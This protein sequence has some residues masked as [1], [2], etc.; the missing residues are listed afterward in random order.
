MLQR[1][2]QTAVLKVMT[3]PLAG[4]S[5]LSHIR[6][7]GLR[8]WEGPS[9]LIVAFD[10]QQVFHMILLLGQCDL[11]C[12]FCVTRLH[13][14]SW[15]EGS[16][17]DVY[18]EI[19]SLETMVL[20]SL[21][22]R[23]ISNCLHVGGGEPF[24]QWSSLSQLLALM[25]NSKSLRLPTSIVISTNGLLVDQNVLSR[26]MQTHRRLPITIE[27]SFK[28]VN[29]RQFTWLTGKSPN[30]LRTQCENF[31]RAW[32]QRGQS[33]DVRAVLGI[34]H[35]P[36]NRLEVLDEQGRTLD[37]TDYSDEF[38]RLVL[39]ALASEGVMLD[40]DHYRVERYAD[41]DTPGEFWSVIRESC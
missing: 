8:S 27:F 40:I 41:V 6:G 9:G 3:I 39:D 29:D 26:V 10:D 24:L 18:S 16:V 36:R 22:P 2:H 21:S 7:R 30:L 12:K 14:P 19:V 35:N 28:G 5:L 33:F 17:H 15:S 1:Q 20:E 37:F 4:G 32:N 23:S 38:R 11:G 13:S 34:N 25:G 31:H